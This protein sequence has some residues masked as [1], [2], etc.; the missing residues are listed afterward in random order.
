[1]NTPIT[2]EPDSAEHPPD[3][4]NFTPDDTEYVIDMVEGDGESIQRINITRKEFLLLKLTLAKHRGYVP[5][6]AELK[7]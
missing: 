5:A 2:E 4:V 3:W 6:S 7:Q 1:V